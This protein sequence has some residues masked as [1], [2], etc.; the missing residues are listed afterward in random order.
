MLLP[1]HSFKSVCNM[2]DVIGAESNILLYDLQTSRRSD[3]GSYELQLRLPNRDFKE[4]KV[5]SVTRK[6]QVYSILRQAIISSQLA[7]GEAIRKELVAAQLGVS[8]TPVS[9]AI[10]RLAD[11]GLVEIYPQT[12]T[13]VARLWL[14]KIETAQFVRVALETAAIRRTAERANPEALGR[15]RQNLEDQRKAANSR[16]F[17]QFYELDEALHDLI[18]DAAGLVGLR[19][20]ASKERSQIDRVRRLLLHYEARMVETLAEHEAIISAIADK[21]ADR[22]AATMEAHIAQMGKMLLHLKI[23]RPELFGS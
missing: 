6:D 8:R 15:F 10:N 7:P 16:D 21:D 12:G 2:L 14:D 13:F 22:A 11:E 19:E 5:V 9:D 1:K 17:E 3:S 20:I 4:Q 18:C 23:K